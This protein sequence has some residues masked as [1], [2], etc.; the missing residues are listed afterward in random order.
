MLDATPPP[1]G[2]KGR[3]ARSGSFELAPAIGAHLAAAAAAL[4]L[5]D[6]VR[7]VHRARVGL[8]RARALARIA[9]PAAPNEARAFNASARAAMAR[10]SPQRDLAAMEAA[11]RTLAR[12]VDPIAG[13]A[14]LDVASALEAEHARL[15]APDFA[16]A[17]AEIA[18]LAAAL[19]HWPKITPKAADKGA[20]RLI[21]R[22]RTAYDRARTDGD[23]EVRH[24]WRK[25]EKERAALAQFAAPLWPSEVRK[26]VRI[27]KALGETL[28]AERDAQ[29]LIA[30][31]R[32]D[33][34][35]AGNLKAAQ[36]AR[37]A[38]A[39]RARELCRAADALGLDLHT[40][41]VK[42]GRL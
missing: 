30:R 5:Q 17:R 10:L 32:A 4:D 36:A 11:A 22:A 23:I 8:K 21:R 27:G 41:E 38:L 1:G 3:T 9:H 14:L 31:L 33:P 18:S 28:G 16:A 25:R 42:A 34:G 13:R 24:A 40:D 6:E 37:R 15:P 2:R 20:R 7:A 39:A 12:E 35:L 19:A 29:L 26:R